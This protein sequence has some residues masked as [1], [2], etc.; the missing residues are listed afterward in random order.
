MTIRDQINAAGIVPALRNSEAEQCAVDLA[1]VI[2]NIDARQAVYSAFI[3]AHPKLLR[4][5]GQAIQCRAFC[6]AKSLKVK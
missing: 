6:I 2:H 5:E 1:S 3:T 4:W